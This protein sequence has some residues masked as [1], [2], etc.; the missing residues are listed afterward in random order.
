[1]GMG[2]DEGFANGGNG[3][4]GKTTSVSYVVYLGG[5]SHG[6]REASA[7]DFQR[8]ADS[9]RSFLGSYLGSKQKAQEAMVY[10]YT[11][12]INGFVAHLDEE[13]AKEISKSPEVIS[14]F[15]N[16]LRKLHTV[17][18]WEFLGLEKDGAVPDQS[19]IWR[20][21]SYGRDVIIGNLDSGVWPESPSFN[22][23]GLGPVPSRWK[24]F[25]E[26]GADP[27]NKVTCN[28]KLIGARQF[29]QGSPE[30]FASDSPR[31][32]V[33]H[34]THTLAT[35]GGAIVPGANFFGI[36]NGTAKGGS[37][38]ARVAAY[39]VC[40]FHGCFDADIIAGF[41]AAIHDGVDV[42]SV[43]L[44]GRTDPDYL[45]NGIAIGSFHA[46][47][48]GIPVICSAGNDGPDL[49]SVSNGAPWIFT[50]ASGTAGREFVS[51]VSLGNRR[52]AKGL[53]L[54]SGRMPARKF[55]PMIDS[56]K[57]KAP[58]ATAIQGQLCYPGSL[59]P[60]K[61]EG[62]I[63]VCLRGEV[64][65]M[66][67]AQEVAKAG[68]VGMVLANDAVF[69]DDLSADLYMIPAVHVNYSEATVIYSYLNSTKL[70]VG[71]IG[72]PKAH[73]GLKPAP[74]IAQTSSRGPNIVTP[75]ILKPDILAPGVHILAA[76]SKG[77]PPANIPFDSRRV[78]FNILS[79][80]SMACPHV[81][82]V[83]GLLKTI[84]P[85][86]SPA[87][88]RSAIMTTAR[89]RDNTRT[90]IKD[91]FMAKANPFAYGAGH[92]QP[93]HAM[94]PG[95]VYDLTGQDYLNFLCAIGYNAT[96]MSTFSDKMFTCPSEPMKIEDLNYPSISIFNLSR[97]IT[98]NRTLKNVGLP[99]TYRVRV[100]PPTGV[101]VSVKPTSLTFERVGE[102]K[103]FQ[104]S[105]APKQASVLQS[106]VFGQLIWSDG[107]HN[108][109]SPLVVV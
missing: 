30:P 60:K 102:E 24:G 41:D 48:R 15:P 107:K 34:G 55:F 82:G 64:D 66:E 62:K 97:P 58:N 108:V 28:R 33:G 106:S 9:H 89:T 90:G 26:E 61:V 99:G 54:A 37:P 7:E 73:Y 35:A 104:V 23:Q 31:D 67:K 50:V 11:K 71:H 3:V 65:K 45:V 77:V 21:A 53:S 56:L 88:L 78:T 44:G 47:Q 80:T 91:S 2:R 1:M 36:A 40:G 39:K 98:V 95:L 81:S 42:I 13:T 6:I 101:S 32:F 84:Y 10:S 20:R 18:S 103:T 29:S 79:G 72:A 92:V 68:G 27:K 25:C 51:R 93:N 8:A 46:V 70:P 63:V 17:N 76:Y 22:D 86:W 43:S 94:D 69:G 49:Y 100:K 87:A 85:H 75:Q 105:L 12:N 38:G 5:H 19:S 4:T 109:R 57:A 74:V 52:H 14:V 96:Q 59:D 83:V 16:K